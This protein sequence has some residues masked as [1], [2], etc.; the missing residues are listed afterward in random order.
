MQGIHYDHRAGMGRLS[1]HAANKLKA[2]GAKVKVC[3]LLKYGAG[4]ENRTRNQ[5]LG[6]MLVD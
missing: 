1:V 5:Q 4:D 3:K 2:A 6:R